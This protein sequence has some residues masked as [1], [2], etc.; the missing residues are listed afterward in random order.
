MS[1]ETT[2]PAASPE[3][4]SLMVGCLD[5]AYTEWNSH[6]KGQAPTLVFVHA[7]GFH[8]RVWD[9][10][11]ARF[12]DRHSI[13]ID[14]PAHGRSGG[15]EVTSWQTVADQIGGLIENLELEA[16]CG[17]GHSM[18]GHVLL[19]AICGPFSHPLHL[20]LIDPMIASPERYGSQ[21]PWFPDGDVHP[22]AKRKRYFRTPQEMIERFS[23]REPYRTFTPAALHNYC[24]YGLVPRTD[25]QEGLELACTPE[26]EAS[27]YMTSQASAG[28]LDMLDRADLPILVVRAPTNP[29]LGFKSS[30]TWRGLAEALPNARDLFMPHLSHFMP[31]EAPDEMANI[32]AKEISG[33]ST[34]A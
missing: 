11:I 14:L 33:F 6:L 25:E 19:R 22:T 20:V 1:N 26:A 18:G 8:A 21:S 5:L 12:P 27:V 4:K 23:D 16:W 13:A 34:N 31:F 28:I 10:I 29:Q 2:Y 30:P 24:T 32:I 15:Y 9:E 3:D 17:I 7:T